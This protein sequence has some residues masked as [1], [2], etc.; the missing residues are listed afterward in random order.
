MKKTKEQSDSEIQTLH[1]CVPFEFYFSIEVRILMLR[2]TLEYSFMH[3]T[4]ADNGDLFRVS[5]VGWGGG[6]GG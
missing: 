4:R 3:Y 5:W 2:S 1:E 6:N